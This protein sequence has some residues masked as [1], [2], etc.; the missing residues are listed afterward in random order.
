MC[1]LVLPMCF[2]VLEP[3]LK[4]KK[5]GCSNL[6]PILSFFSLTFLITA[7]HPPFLLFVHQQSLLLSTTRLRRAGTA[8]VSSNRPCASAG[9]VA[10]VYYF[11]S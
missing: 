4:K 1:V 3:G 7:L 5:L 10:P 8:L 6:I 2:G 11:G 9:V